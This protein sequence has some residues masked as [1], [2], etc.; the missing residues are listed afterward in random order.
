ME[1]QLKIFARPV[2]TTALVGLVVLAT[3]APLA[4]AADWPELSLPAPGRG[5]GE[6]DAALVVGIESY[7]AIQPVPGAVRNA[8]DWANYFAE[9]RGM[10]FGSY[11]VLL[12]DQATLDEI[13]EAAEDV[14]TKVKPKGTLWFV[15]IGHGAPAKDGSDGLLVGWDAKQT[16]ASLYARSLSQKT[17]AGMLG[18]GAQAR[19]VMVVDACFS[20]RRP[21]GAPLV[22]G[23]QPILLAQIAP[24][25]SNS[26]LLLGAG[27]DQFAGPLPG[28]NRPAF[29][30]LVLGG[31]RG[32]ADDNGDGLVTGFEVAKFTQSALWAL[33]KDRTQTPELVGDGNL[34]LAN[35]AYE[36]RP[37]LGAIARGSTQPGNPT[38]LAESPR[39]AQSFTTAKQA[40]QPGKPSPDTDGL[41]AET[42][43]SSTASNGG[44]S[45]L[46]IGG[47]A[48][49]AV[50]AA[51]IATGGYFSVRTR[52]IEQ[53][54]STAPSF[55]TATDDEGKRDRVLQYVGYGVGGAAL[56]GGL[57]MYL[58]GRRE[59]SVS[60]LPSIGPQYAGANLV[61]RF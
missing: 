20:G 49:L 19:T 12:N 24:A 29:S 5:G 35:G 2:V 32:W 9:T 55:S 21:D 41:A 8:K 17:L 57:I 33:V 54:L 10:P 53:D 28:Q 27:T 46:L 48:M 45:A 25:L 23:L 50:G 3:A 15:F 61:A 56:A 7:A 31:L 4:S 30:Y 36:A 59:P 58:L 16:A 34:P 18:K 14:A 11:K 51:G 42:A 13:K 47:I 52:S 1:D 22:A 26:V 60:A 39:P 37:D 40:E 44:S 6:N 38:P 43:P